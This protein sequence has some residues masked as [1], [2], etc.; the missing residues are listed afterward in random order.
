MQ[1]YYSNYS[2]ACD[3]KLSIAP[4]SEFIKLALIQ[5]DKNDR[6]LYEAALHGGVDEILESKVPLEL[7]SLLT[8]RT[9]FVLVEGP[10]GIGKST[11][12]WELCRKWNSWKSLQR[13]KI[14]LLLKLQER[15]V[16]EANSLEDLFYHDDRVLLRGIVREA[17]KC[18]GEG[19]LL[20]LDGFDEMP[21][22]VVKDKNSLV[23][24]LIRGSCLPSTTLLVTSRPS[25][26]YRKDFFP[27]AY[28]HVEIVGFT[29]ECKVKY[30]EIA[31][32]SE[33]DVLIHFKRFIISNPIINSLLYI[34]VN[35]AIVTQV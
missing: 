33:P 27:P 20:I 29:D 24:K 10:P 34:P 9:R 35:C 16:Q 11:L 26:L 25:A 7:D 14:I 3:D 18:E 22:S 23:M 6:H 15:R 30:A 8:T 4:C 19:F 32:Q 12:C 1:S 5:K 17:F 31:F 28:R 21:I 2:V 13:Y